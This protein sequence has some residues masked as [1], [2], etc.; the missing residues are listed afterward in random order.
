MEELIKKAE[1]KGINVEDLIILA[2]SKLDPNEGVKIRLE[3]AEKYLSEAKDYLSKGDAIQ[4]SEKAYK[5][6][7]EIVKAL[8]EKFNLPEYQQAIKE[9]RWYTYNLGHAAAKLS[10]KL[11]DWVKAGWNSA[12]VLHVWGFHEAKFDLD[13]VKIMISDIERMI[14][15]ARK[16][17]LS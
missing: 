9:G 3:L 5:T 13:T 1:E 6:A 4:A 10:L 16:V 15:E 2:L 14:R 8:A 7:E 11:G 17:I 12:Y